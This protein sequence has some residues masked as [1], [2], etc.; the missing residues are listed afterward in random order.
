MAQRK[1]TEKQQAFLD[2][3]FDKANGNFVEAKRL[4]GYSENVATQ[5]IVDSL[6]EEI[7]TLTQKYISRIGVKAA[8]AMN[9]VIENPTD[10]GNKEKMQAAKD[11]LDRAGYKPKDK[12]EVETKD[13]LFILPAKKE[14]NAESE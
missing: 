8:V 6:E 12:V 10:L 3:L 9:H 1:L 7:Y 13:P 11:I 5:S 14:D 4:A 2:V